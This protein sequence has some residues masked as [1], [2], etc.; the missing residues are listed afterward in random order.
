MEDKL[1]QAFDSI[2][3][4]ETL[5]KSTRSFLSQEMTRRSSRRF[6]FAGLLPAAACLLFFLVCAGGYRFYMTPV[7]VISIDVN[8]SWELGVNRFDRVVSSQ[9]YNEEGSA[10]LSGEDLRFLS[11]DTA[12]RQLLES[13]AMQDYLSE[14]AVLSITVV[15]DSEDSAR[16]LDSLEGC[17][18]SGPNVYCFQAAPEDVEKAHDCGLSYGKYNAFLQLQQ[19]E[20]TVTPE[21]VRHL[22][23][24]E[25]RDLILRHSG[26][27]TDPSPQE[28]TGGKGQKRKG[29]ALPRS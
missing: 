12:V 3:A 27:D 23:M 29:Q 28:Q 4:E 19:L 16:M 26:S 17:A 7:A 5:K 24:R 20:P 18:A 25:I 11:Y 14:D 21:D 10:V 15:S 22:S 8:P 2:H 1:K 13:D 9:G 6:S